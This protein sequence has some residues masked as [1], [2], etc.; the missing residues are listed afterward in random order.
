MGG[1]SVNSYYPHLFAPLT[2]RGK[3]VKNRIVSAP[4]SCPYMLEPSE[5]GF[6]NYSADAAMYYLGSNQMF[7]NFFSD[8]LRWH[9]IPNM[10]RMTTGIHAYGALACI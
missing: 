4:H 3:T 2:V 9:Q 8:T 1:D 10:R 6:F 5:N 7:F